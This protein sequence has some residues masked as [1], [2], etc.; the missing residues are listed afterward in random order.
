VRLSRN[1]HSRA[2]SETLGRRILVD[3]RWSDA[4]SHAN[5]AE[6]AGIGRFAREVIPRL[7]GVELLR[8]GPRVLHPA[9]PLWLAGVLARR[10]P[11][12]YFTPG[13]NVPAWSPVPFVFMLW[14]LIH[15]HI[16]QRG[17]RAK[18]AYFNTVIRRAA[19]AA[20][21]VVTG[22]TASREEIVE[23]A[24][25]AAERVEVVPAGVAPAF[26]PEG[27]A[28]D[29][30]YPYVLYVGNRRP[31]KN[32]PRLLEA[33]AH[34]NGCAPL[35][36]VLTGPPDGET[37]RLARGLGIGDRV[38]FAGRVPERDLPALYRGA[39][40]VALPS[41]Y[42]GFGLPALEAMASGTPLVAAA[43]T[44]LPELVGD[45]A[46]LVDPREVHALAS[47]LERLH[48]DEALRT[49]LRAR[50][51]ERAAA[52][53]WERSASLLGSVLERAARG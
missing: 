3:G 11:D 36:L 1:L 51:L 23:W 8:D 32:L 35:S 30:G 46:I 5:P 6:V 7:D 9:E 48:G 38:V 25:I 28:A 14:D 41:L 4:R 2:S 19:R 27:P 18:R 49:E 15:L 40:A 20:R 17:G 22:S 12:L 52:Y 43:A 45:A 34:A 10:R 37:E 53:T 29:P 21:V 44:S 26:G 16:E 24:E 47:A 31:H 39:R 13:F 50:G 33:F 42:E